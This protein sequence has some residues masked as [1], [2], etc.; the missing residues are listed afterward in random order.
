[1][2]EK[3]IESIEISTTLKEY[4]D[5]EPVSGETE[6]VSSRENTI[7]YEDVLKVRF[8]SF[9]KLGKKNTRLG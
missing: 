7:L 1:M 5:A 6:P 3:D 2:I 8:L 9:I 4:D